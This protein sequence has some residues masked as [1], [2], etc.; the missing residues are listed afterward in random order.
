MAQENIIRHDIIQLDFDTNLKELTRITKELDELKKS[1]S[2]GLGDDEFDKLKDSV[3]DTDDALDKVKK[4]ANNADDSLDKVKKAANNTESALDKVKKTA[5]NASSKLLE[6]GKK[7]AVAA[8]NG[9]KKIAG[10]SFKAV[11]VGI[12]AAATAVGTLVTK[13]VQ[14]YADYEQLVGG[15]DTLFKGDSKTVQKYANDA[16]KTAGLSANEYME[17]VTGFSASMIQ[18]VGGDTKKAAELSN[19]AITDMSDNA[20]KMGTSMDSI[21]QTYQSL[22]RG[23]YAM[24]DN[25]KLGYGGTKEEM[26]RLIKDAA[27]L[28]SSVDANSTSY[29][30]LVKAIHVVQ[31]N[32]GITGTTAKEASS[33][34]SGS[35]AS[36]KSAW[37]NLLPALIQGGDSFDQCVDN[38]VESVKTFAKNV[39]PAI[40]KALS[41]VGKL[42]EELAPIIEQE[43]PA[44]VDELL[45]PLIKAATSLLSGLIKALPSIAKAIIKEAP[46]IFKQL[47][48]AIA[49]TFGEQFPALKQFG[50]SLMENAKKIA[51][52]VPYILGLVGA[53]M[54]LAKIKSITGVFS[55]LFGGSKGGKGGGM[56]SGLTS[57]AKIPVKTVLKGMANLGIIFGGMM[58]LATAYMALAPYIAQLSDLK[59]VAKV[60]VVIAITGVLGAALAKLGG[61]VGNIPVATVAKGL[62]NMAIMLVGVGALS[63]ALAWVTTK[64]NGMIDVKSILKLAAIMTAVG[65]VGAVLAVFAGIVGLIPIPTVLMGL[66]NIALVLA[67]VTGVIVAF[68]ALSKIDGFSEFITTGGEL[69]A[70]LFN[71]LGKIVGSAIGGLGE[72]LTNSLPKIGK[73]LSDFAVSLKPLFTMF[74]GVDMAGVGEFFNAIGSF[75]LK[76]AGEKLLSLFTGGTDFSGVAKGLGSLSGEGVKKFF[77]MVQGIDPVA[78][79]NG[80]KFFDCL[81]G[82]SKLPNVGGLG[83]LFSGTND[84]EGVASGLKSLTGEGVKNFFAMVAGMET[85][86]FDNAK[87]FFNCLDGISK[88]PNVGGI[89]QIF[90]GE[91]DFKGVADG[92]KTLSSDGVKNFFAMVEGLTPA[93]FD[94]TKL[95]FEALGSISELPN[96]GGFWDKIAGNKTTSLG[97]LAEDLESFST[98]AKG[99]FDQINKLKIS[100]LNGLWESLKKSEDVTANVSK[101]IDEHIDDIVKK[102]SE[103]PE[104]MGEALKSS[105]KTL[106]DSLVSV[107]KD[108]VK[109]SVAPVNKVLEAANW[110]LK[111]FGSKKRVIT[112]KP[113]A[114][115]T[116]GHS[117][118][119]ALVNDGNGAELVQM[120]N[121]NSFIPSGRNVFIPNA[122][123]GMKVLPAEQTA[124]LMGK[125]KPTFNYAD[126]IGDIDL[127]SY[128]DNS[129]GLVSKIN[130][131]VSYDGMSGFVLSLGKGMV[132]TFTGEMSAWIDKLFEE[133]GALSLANYVASKGVSQWRSTVIRALKMEGQYSAANVER[134]LY[135]MQTE[136]GGNPKAINLWDSNAKKGIPSKG[137]MQVIDPTFKAYARNGFDKN[138]YDPLSN[139]LASIR[140][141]VSRY[142]SLAKAYQGKGYAN[143][144]V[145]TKPSV[146]GE[147]GAE[148]AIPLTA[149]KRKRAVGLWAETGDMLGLSSYTPER[150][151]GTYTTN[152]TENNTYS[153]SFSITISGSENDRELAR[154]VKR[155]ISES[156]DEVFDSMSSKNPKLQ[157][158]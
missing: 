49:E 123:K 33:T 83:Q 151:S 136:S 109:A 127:W 106:G 112:W 34:I 14:A 28:D 132:S 75:M 90:T 44:M 9:L 142:G 47:G 76:M 141:A 65:A 66:A 30:N 16:F 78:F 20:N 144:G 140:Y 116:D 52:C 100:N 40:I 158:V 22:A 63:V 84:F 93:A 105:G 114:K 19:M 111:E 131:S 68:G 24:L 120:P 96:E 110:I 115:G 35:L 5:S 55:G 148:M 31:E 71:V 97:S 38:L 102:I 81:D 124:Q 17:T 143:G 73:N 138:I 157:E 41:G 152:Y 58:I 27:K 89:G 94:N 12:G 4:A 85:V 21:I 129:K 153:P 57:L 69:L 101:I 87:A 6:L 130:D 82:I 72:G 95:L 145:A 61:I 104:K 50:E 155:W 53:F 122:P 139:I 118:G 80:K 48:S 74:K 156:L 125:G 42:I 108:A 64:V 1:I 2:G 99:F 70:K 154:K 29:A 56:F 98:K 37:G 13:S 103:L 133:E 18:S 54:A 107:W 46:D 146:F 39:K 134:T 26:K 117:G 113:Y 11:T 25:L 8:F 137:L 23:N 135:Q 126:G 79:E 60:S 51:K 86:A 92:L 150:D 32:M 36:M 3:N 128:I 59:S 15:V 77:N 62:A 10:L 147:D 91:N 121:G 88:L 7:G 67:G 119:N 45:P 43:F 149:D